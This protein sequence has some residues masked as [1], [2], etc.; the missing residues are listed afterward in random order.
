M[1]K[2]EEERRKKGSGDG[3]VAQWERVCYLSLRA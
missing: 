1:E 2:R 3:E